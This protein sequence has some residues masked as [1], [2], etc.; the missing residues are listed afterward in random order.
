MTALENQHLEEPHMNLTRIDDL[1]TK[2]ATKCIDP[3]LRLK[4]FPIG[5]SPIGG[6]S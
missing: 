2:A 1:R 3:S 4:G 6:S 5:D